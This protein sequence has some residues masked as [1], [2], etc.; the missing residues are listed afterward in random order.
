[1]GRTFWFKLSLVRLAQ[2]VMGPLL[3]SAILAASASLVICAGIRADQDIVAGSDKVVAKVGD[4]E[5]T[6]QEVDKL[7]KPRMVSVENEIYEIKR[8]AILSIAD[9]YVVQQA[10]RQENLSETEYLKKKIGDKLTPVTEQQARAY[11]DAHQADIGQPF[12][13]VKPALMRY[14][15]RKQIQDR[16]E[17]LLDTLRQQVGFTMLLKPPRADVATDGFPTLGPEDAP[18]T[19]VEFTDFQCPFCRRAEPTIKELRAKYGD[20]VRLVHR[21]FPLSFHR[22]ALKA[23]VAAHCA[24]DQ[25]RFWQYHDA[26]FAEQSKLSDNEFKNIAKKL[27]LDMPKFQNCLD[28]D[29][30]VD[31]IKRD[32]EAGEALGVDGTPAFFINGVSLVGAQPPDK[33]EA[34]INSELSQAASKN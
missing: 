26:L 27:N 24:G 7:I 16:R 17:E 3:L 19:I 30:H 34:L 18:V 6:E 29:E 25:G 11:Y 14:L 10:A 33:F 23:A 21:D 5:I 9:D 13:K 32:L 15:E 28:K 2:T 8:Q 31:Q 4:H 22:Q 20:K 12:D 1:M